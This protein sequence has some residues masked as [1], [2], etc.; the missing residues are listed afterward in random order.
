MS[1]LVFAL[2]AYAAVALEMGL[3][4]LR[5]IGGA[6][7]VLILAVYIGLMAP[8]RA[9]VWAMG[10]LGLLVDL[11]GGPVPGAVVVGPATLGYLVGA[12][13]VLQLRTLVFRESV[14]TLAVLVF[15]VGIMVQL[16][17][18]FMFSMRGVWILPG[19]RLADWHPADELAHRFVDLVKTAVVALAVGGLL[20]KSTPAW[21]FPGKT[22]IDR[23]F[24]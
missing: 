21:G 19:E 22:R 7:F 4:T 15:A 17:I 12:F 23:R 6:S 14:L 11:K 16:V 1:W 2:F 9:G 13:A 8:A 10:L 18:V 3:Q 5:L 24:H 20:L